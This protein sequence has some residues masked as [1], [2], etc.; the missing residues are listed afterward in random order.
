MYFPVACFRQEEESNNHG[1]EAHGAGDHAGHQV[2]VPPK[3]SILCEVI[4]IMLCRAR[5]I[6]CKHNGFVT[7]EQGHGVWDMMPLG[8]DFA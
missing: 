1:N 5:Y 2:G 3:Q 6:A 8:Q 7:T 4:R